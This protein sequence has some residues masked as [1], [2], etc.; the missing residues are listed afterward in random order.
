VNAWLFNLIYVAGWVAMWFAFRL[1]KSI[2]PTIV[3]GAGVWLPLIMMRI[4][5]RRR[6]KRLDLIEAGR[7]PECAYDLRGSPSPKGPLF[8][9]CPECGYDMQTGTRHP[10]WVARRD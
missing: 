3:I 7:C 6:Q 2:W 4:V 10:K 9:I 5:Q 1:S 8:S